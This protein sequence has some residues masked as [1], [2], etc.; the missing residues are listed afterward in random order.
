MMPHIDMTASM[1]ATDG[2]SPYQAFMKHSL[3]VALPANDEEI[4]IVQYANL[5]LLPHKLAMKVR[6][7]LKRVTTNR[8]INALEPFKQLSD[9][10]KNS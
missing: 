9:E 8:V 3:F 2:I 4:R 1:L 10:R 5:E 7:E 6:T